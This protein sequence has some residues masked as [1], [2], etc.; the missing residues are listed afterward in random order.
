M[1][2]SDRP[3]LDVTTSLLG[4]TWRER[5]DARGRSAATTITQQTEI[6][7]LVARILAG[8]GV[9]P[10]EAERFL[11][12]AI[13]DLMPDP[14]TL[15]DMD[16]ASDRLAGAIGRQE[17]VAIF[18]DYD[19][20]GAASSALLA[21]FLRHFGCETEIYIPDRII[22]GYGPNPAAIGELAGRGATI[23][24]TVD[25][26]SAS[27]EALE[28]ARSLGVDVVVIDHHLMHEAHPPA[29]AVVNPNREDDLSGLSYL[30][31][32]GVTFL[33]LVAVAAKLRAAGRT[34][35]DL[36]QWVDLVALATI[37]D[38]VPLK[39]LNRAYVV[40]GLAAMHAG[41]NSGLAALARCARLDGPVRPYHLGF[42]LGPR[43][44]AGGR[45]GDAALGARLLASDDPG[46]IEAICA[47]LEMLNRE[48]QA[49]ENAALE[50][51]YA[52]A[53]AEIGAGQGPSVLL[54]ESRDWHPGIVGL[55]AARLKERFRRPAFALS[56]DAAGRATGSGRS[57]S[58]ADLGH[59]VRAA[60]A[61]GILLK[62]GGHPMAA[63][64][65]VTRDRLADLRAFLEDRLRDAVAAARDGDSLKIDAA[66][67]ARG[68]TIELCDLVER[69]GPFGQGHPRPVFAFPAHA[70][71]NPRLVGRDSI[72]F[73]LRPPDGASLRAI[74]FRAGGTAFG[75]ALMQAPDSLH[76]AGTLSAEWWEGSR[77]VQLRAIDAAVPQ[78][79]IR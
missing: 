45:I 8:R 35:P 4:Q 11:S 53:D 68:A 38:V 22:E 69:A 54:V 27:F 65:T 58:G 73:L 49:Q 7:D 76:V 59:A 66:M 10:E 44:N 13:R 30:C 14:R 26:G 71:R 1:A 52:Q 33:V 78:L 17:R 75:Q 31:A 23:I 67:T 72:S 2:D 3:F 28:H 39:G 15:T 34:I 63:G 29:V 57:V 25:C 74:A 60:V 56:F 32:A 50:I 43:I 77:R 16:A 62:G 51:A 70:I 40:K 36:L 47:K 21:R 20:D 79:H 46:E 9:G 42:L 55:I 37:C 61:A 48:R 24:V 12:P 6:P 19:V 18:G 64:L 5:L 41:A